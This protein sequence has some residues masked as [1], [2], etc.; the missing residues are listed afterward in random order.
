MS[1]NEL[2]TKLNEVTTSNSNADALYEMT[3]LVAMNRDKNAS[4]GFV[5][6]ES[7][8]RL[9]KEGVPLFTK[10][11][12]ATYN[13]VDPS[14]TLPLFSGPLITIWVLLELIMG[15]KN[16]M[17][18]LIEVGEKYLLSKE[19]KPIPT[20]L[21]VFCKFEE[22][23]IVWQDDLFALLKKLL[24]PTEANQECT[25]CSYLLLCYLTNIALP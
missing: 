7:V 9:I 25:S 11:F 21:E 24:I 23:V 10:P 12:W 18:K 20:E 16:T 14:S 5:G 19:N 6:R 15:L 1:P 13:L 17:S 4:V 8:I 2:L 22:I 3:V